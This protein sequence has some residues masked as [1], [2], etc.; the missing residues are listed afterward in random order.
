MNPQ[1]RIADLRTA[2]H[3]HNHR[4]YILD[5]PCISDFEFDQLLKE[6]EQLESQF[7]EFY[8]ENSPTMRVGGSIVKS[9]DTVVHEYPMLSLGNTYN[10]EELADW[11]GRVE[12]LAPE[13]TF[14][15]ELKY[16]GVAIGIR[17]EHGKLVQAVTRG[18][19]TQ[20]D[21][22]TTNV[23]TIRSVPLQLNG[24]APESFEIRGEIVLPHAAFERLN[25]AR[26]AEGHPEFANPRNCASGTLKLQ[27]SSVVATRE[28]DAYLYFVLPLQKTCQA[29]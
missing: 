8:D 4:Y 17:Y 27:D 2:L 9:F 24:Q 1:E 5:Q 19:G 3:E 21:D 22:I 26:R 28:L 15:C 23:R 25:G 16:D 6:L 11:I 29:Q 20:G 13:S 14:V 10:W 18:D 7:P 12:K